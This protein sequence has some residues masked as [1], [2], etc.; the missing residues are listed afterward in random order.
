MGLADQ[1][2]RTTILYVQGFKGSH[3]H[4][5]E[6]YNKYSQNGKYDIESKANSKDKSTHYEIKKGLG[7]INSKEGLVNLKTGQYELSKRKQREK[8]LEK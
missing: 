6:M 8:S 2:F 7:G 1:A 4:K 3:E 5:R